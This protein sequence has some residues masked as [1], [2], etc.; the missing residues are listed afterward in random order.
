MTKIA[1]AKPIEPNSVPLH[2]ALSCLGEIASAFPLPNDLVQSDAR[3]LP[4]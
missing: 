3:V 1:E 4:L 2:S